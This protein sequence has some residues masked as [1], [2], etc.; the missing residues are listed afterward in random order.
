MLVA[1]ALRSLPWIALVLAVGCGGATDGTRSYQLVGVDLTARMVRQGSATLPPGIALE[2]RGAARDVV[3]TEAPARRRRVTR[4]GALARS[5][6]SRQ[7]PGS[8]QVAKQTSGQTLS[9]EARRARWVAAARQRAANARRQVGV[10]TGRSASPPAARTVRRSQTVRRETRVAPAVT[11][12]S[13]TPLSRREQLLSAARAR[14]AAAR[15]R[16]AGPEAQPRDVSVQSRETHQLAQPRP[17]PRAARAT[18]GA[19]PTAQH[20]AFERGALEAQGIDT[21]PA[22]IAPPAAVAPGQLR[23]V[24]YRQPGS[25]LR[26]HYQYRPRFAAPA[27]SAPAAPAASAAVCDCPCAQP[28]R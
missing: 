23:R 16:A 17:Q 21:Q 26:T 24:E 19:P 11:R 3:Y 2:Q 27:A 13:A 18:A 22:V 5:A 8:Q 7:Q 10:A 6:A 9:P 4:A 25:A 12:E 14:T 20:P 1:P 28:A 15:R